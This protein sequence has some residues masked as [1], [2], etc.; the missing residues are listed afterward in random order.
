MR[1]CVY[2]YIRT[3]VLDCGLLQRMCAYWLFYFPF[4][5]ILQQR[6]FAAKQQYLTYKTERRTHFSQQYSK[7]HSRALCISLDC[8]P[9]CFHRHV[10]ISD[11]SKYVLRI[12]MHSIYEFSKDVHLTSEE[13]KLMCLTI[14]GFNCCSLFPRIV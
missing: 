8:S 2:S 13:Q 5:S 11:T 3:Y 4:F 12:L 10:K 14:V 6:R 9:L 7:I 1:C